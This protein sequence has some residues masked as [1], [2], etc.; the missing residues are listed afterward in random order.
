MAKHANKMVT[1]FVQVPQGYLVV[2]AYHA[3]T[4]LQALNARDFIAWG[5]QLNFVP[6][7]AV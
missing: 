7:T 2:E 6:S 3:S 1:Q 5:S 4:K